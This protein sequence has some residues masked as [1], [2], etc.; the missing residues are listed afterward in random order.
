MKSFTLN[1]RSHSLR[2]NGS[3]RVPDAPDRE[4]TEPDDS[5][6]PEDDAPPRPAAEEATEG[7]SD[8]SSGT[9][10]P[11]RART[12]TWA[13]AALGVVASTLLA[14]AVTTYFDVWSSSRSPVPA[15]QGLHVESEVWWDLTRDT[16][17]VRVAGAVDVAKLEQDAMDSGTAL[18][19][20]VD[21]G[22]T[23]AGMMRV[24]VT[25]MNFTKVPV[26]VT[27]V[28][29][30][31][32]GETPAPGGDLLSCG[33]A[34]GSIG[35][36]RLRVDLGSSDKAAQEYDGEKVV[37]HY[38][39]QEMQLAKQDEP[40]VFDLRVEAG[41]TTASYVLDVVYQQGTEKGRVVVDNGGKPFVLAPA[42]GEVDSA[43][44]CDEAMTGWKRVR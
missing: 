42:E 22:S 32:T 10:R 27:E 4:T 23:Y 8:R 39:V 25:L 9:S 1:S 30:R 36:T 6:S 7:P 20:L 12:R 17:A 37:G 26:S 18:D 35:I 21:G 15:G 40:A 29:A 31:V 5:P 2:S 34:E 28:R 43:Y 11:G 33:G 41:D 14:T 19:G 44:R 24:R 3:K 38:P 13:A 16:K